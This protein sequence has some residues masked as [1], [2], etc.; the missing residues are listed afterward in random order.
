MPCTCDGYPAPAPDLHSGPVADALC[1]VMQEHEAR[2]EMSCFDAASL[3]WWQDHKERDRRRVELVVITSAATPRATRQPRQAP[4]RRAAPHHPDSSA[5]TESG[6]HRS[7]TPTACPM[8]SS[9]SRRALCWSAASCR[10]HDDREG[11]Q[12]VV[13]DVRQQRPSPR[14][15]RHQS[16]RPRPWPRL[17]IGARTVLKMAVFRGQFLIENARKLTSNHDDRGKGSCHGREATLVKWRR[18]QQSMFSP[19]TTVDGQRFRRVT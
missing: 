5:E 3:K 2:G 13:R 10:L 18:P 4:D 14:R 17:R 19:S 6:C 8:T 7:Q 9:C 16:D 11:P 12:G 15:P 1:K